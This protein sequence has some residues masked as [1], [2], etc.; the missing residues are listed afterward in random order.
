MRPNQTLHLEAGPHGLS[1]PGRR[2]AATT[3][4]RPWVSGPGTDPGTPSRVPLELSWV[5]QPKRLLL[6]L[7]GVRVMSIFFIW[8]REGWIR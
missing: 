3:T 4:S 8:K 5:L 2:Q 1:Q 6:G 7:L